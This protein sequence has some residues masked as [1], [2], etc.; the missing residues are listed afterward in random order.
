MRDDLLQ[1]T[2][3]PKQTTLLLTKGKLHQKDV[4]DLSI[5]EEA[6]LMLKSKAHQMTD[7]VS[8]G[9]EHASIA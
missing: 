9:T 2:V 4:T 1:K 8:K 7:S 5:D 3:K 6:D